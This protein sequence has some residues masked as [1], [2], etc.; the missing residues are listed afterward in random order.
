MEF[1][2]RAMQNGARLS[3][4]QLEEPAFGWMANL[5]WRDGDQQYTLNVCQPGYDDALRLLV[6]AG[7]EHAVRLFVR[8]GDR[9]GARA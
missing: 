5:Q 4:R 6:V 7:F 3:V 2:D 1:L 9:V 8:P